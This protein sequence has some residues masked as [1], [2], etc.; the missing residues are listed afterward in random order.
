MAK[1]EKTVV[2]PVSKV[3]LK[4]Y[5]QTSATILRNDGLPRIDDKADKAVVWLAANGFKESDVELFGEKPANWDAVFSPAPVIEPAVIET[6][7]VA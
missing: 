6:A 5:S 4:V 2:K 3:R 1:V 7:A